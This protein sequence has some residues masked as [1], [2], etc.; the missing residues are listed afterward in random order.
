MSK[1]A[2]PFISERL[3]LAKPSGTIDRE[4][5][6]VYGVRIVNNESGNGRRY[7]QPVLI[8]AIPV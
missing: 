6:I 8:A 7:P 1:S 3:A 4:K 2:P 5:G